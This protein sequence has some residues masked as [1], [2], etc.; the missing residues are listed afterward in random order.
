MRVSE[1]LDHVRKLVPVSAV[2][3]IVAVLDHPDV[4]L[5]PGNAPTAVL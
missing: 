5:T 1:V 4:T 3:P 2:S